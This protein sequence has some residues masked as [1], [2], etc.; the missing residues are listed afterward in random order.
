MTPLALVEELYS[1]SRPADRCPHL[2]RDR[3]GVCH[4][5][6]GPLAIADS[7]TIDTASL[8]IWCLAGREQ[9]PVCIFFPP[10]DPSPAVDS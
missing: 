1:A 9:W 10:P 4:C 3:P 2:R 6:A 8:Q 5:V 7:N